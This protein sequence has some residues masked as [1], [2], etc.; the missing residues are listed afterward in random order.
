MSGFNIINTNSV[1]NVGSEWEFNASGLVAS[2][3]GTDQVVI[4]GSGVFVTGIT[5]TQGVALNSQMLRLTGNT[6]SGNTLQWRDWQYGDFGYYQSINGT[7]LTTEDSG[8]LGVHNG[9]DKWEI[10]SLRWDANSVSIVKN[11][12]ISGTIT[13]SGTA[14]FSSTISASGDIIMNGNNLINT[15]SISNVGSEWDF[16]ANGL[17]ASISGTDKLTVNGSGLTLHDNINM[18]G[19]AITGAAGGSFTG[20]LDMQGYKIV[21][22][23]SNSNVGSKVGYAAAGVVSSISGTSIFTV[24]A[25]GTTTSGYSYQ[26]GD[27][28]MTNHGIHNLSGFDSGDN[29]SFTFNKTTKGVD[30][31]SDIF[32][33]YDSASGSKLFEVT[34]SGVVIKADLIVKGE[35]ISQTEVNVEIYDKL[36][37]LSYNASGS[38]AIDGTGLTV[39][40]LDL[41]NRPSLL[42]GSD[43]NEWSLNRKL[44]ITDP[45]DASGS[46]VLLQPSTLHFSEQTSNIQFGT[47]WRITVDNTGDNIIFQKYDGTTWNN[48]F[49]F[50]GQ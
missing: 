41:T 33:I 13:V 50:N 8:I 5:D 30:L 24:T 36:I 20:D 35:T 25:S 47:S 12:D 21:N 17:V 26:N 27:L 16:N 22:I 11:T 45:A 39:G 15:N 29:T 4:N 14:A 2:I 48:K 9:N 7:V 10:T 31:T 42:Y 28:D 1:S 23:E 34:G 3:S 43:D 6:S 49:E 32:R 44:Y 19:Y 46:T 40:S 18:N 38:N 37:Q